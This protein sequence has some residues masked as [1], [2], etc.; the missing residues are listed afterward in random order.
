MPRPADSPDAINKRLKGTGIRLKVEAR[1][2][3]LSLRGTFPLKPGQTKAKQTYLA[4]GI[5]DTPYELK[6]AELKAHEVW[7]QLGQGT[8]DWQDWIA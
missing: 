6:M 5:D 4:L 1:G 7:A 3:K 2:R 8:F